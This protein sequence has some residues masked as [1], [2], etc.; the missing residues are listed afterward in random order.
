MGHVDGLAGGHRRDHT[1][2][3]VDRFEQDVDDL[4]VDIA[5]G[6]A[7]L[8]EQRLHAVGELRDV[9]EAERRGAALDRVSRAEDVIDDV[10]IGSANI[11]A[12]K[13]RFHDVEP[14]AAFLEEDL[15]NFLHVHVGRHRRFQTPFASNPL[16]RNHAASRT[17]LYLNYRNSPR[18]L[19]RSRNSRT[20]RY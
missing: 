4:F 9:H 17:C 13:P 20:G 14:F 2:Q 16:S 1:A 7:K 10:K 19:E 11:E 8:V 15:E 5:L 3:A 6:C 18:N 12:Q